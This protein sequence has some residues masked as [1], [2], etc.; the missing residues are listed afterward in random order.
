R[1]RADDLER[2]LR[3]LAVPGHGIGRGGVH[4]DIRGDVVELGRPGQYLAPNLELDANAEPDQGGHVD[5]VFTM[6]A[7]GG[8]H[9]NQLP[10]EHLEARARLDEAIVDPGKVRRW[11]R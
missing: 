4:T 3:Q 7:V 8:G 2:D 1:L 11:A 5:L 10:V 9:V 6:G